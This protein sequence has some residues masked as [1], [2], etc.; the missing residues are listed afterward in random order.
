MEDLG[1]CAPAYISLFTAHT[2]TQTTEDL[3]YHTGCG[4]LVLSHQKDASD[5][6]HMFKHF[7]YSMYVKCIYIYI[8]MYYSKN[9]YTY[10]SS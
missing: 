2:Y 5:C 6:C 4:G 3:R 9:K 8:D 1:D 7:L 10:T